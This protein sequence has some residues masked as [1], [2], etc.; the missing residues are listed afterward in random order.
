MYFFGERA[1]EAIGVVGSGREVDRLATF[2][3]DHHRRIGD[4]YQ[5]CIIAGNAAVIHVVT[6]DIWFR[7]PI[8][9]QRYICRRRVQIIAAVDD[10]FFSLRRRGC[11]HDKQGG[12]QG[13]DTEVFFHHKIE[14][15]S[16]RDILPLAFQQLARHLEGARAKQ[17][18]F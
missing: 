5:T 17:S 10:D 12:E 13:Q 4:R 8:P 11:K 18:V 16:S 1:L 9:G 2:H 14:G 3:R 15:Q 7:I 6:G